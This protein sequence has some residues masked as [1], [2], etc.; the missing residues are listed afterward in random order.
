MTVIIVVTM[1]TMAAAEND[2]R[3]PLKFLVFFP[4]VRSTV[5]VATGVAYLVTCSSGGE[6]FSYSLRYHD[7]TIK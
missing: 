1:K 5:L 7:Y 3:K 6:Q 4:A 2:E